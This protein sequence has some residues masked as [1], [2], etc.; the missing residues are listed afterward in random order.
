[1]LI[2]RLARASRPTPGRQ[3]R[4]YY[5]RMSRQSR[6]TARAPLRRNAATPA[7]RRKAPRR[8]RPQ[9]ARQP[10]AQT[11]RSGEAISPRFEANGTTTSDPKPPLADK[12][13]LTRGRRLERAFVY[14]DGVAPV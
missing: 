6:R 2:P 13:H 5:E 1:M 12:S 7:L 11:A 14:R 8:P 10:P 3:K 9:R 4:R